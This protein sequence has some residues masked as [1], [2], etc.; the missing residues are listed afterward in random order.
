MV[1]VLATEPLQGHTSFLYLCFLILLN[2]TMTCV[3]DNVEIIVIHGSLRIGNH[4]TEGKL[5]FHQ[6]RDATQRVALDSVEADGRRRR[7]CLDAELDDECILE[8]FI[9]GPFEGSDFDSEDYVARC[10]RFFGILPTQN[11]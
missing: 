9:L 7:I 4:C 11:S 10:S 6:A 1:L 2:R 5:S 3:V 8:D